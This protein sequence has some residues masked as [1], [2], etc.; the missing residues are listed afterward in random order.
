MR[1]LLR[2]PWCLVAVV[3]L[4]CS[5]V[6]RSEEVVSDA[7][8]RSIRTVIEAQIAAF[9][10]DDARRAF[11]YATPGIRR[12]I[13]TPERFIE[14]VRSSYPVVYRPLSVT[15]LQTAVVDGE[16]FQAVQMVDAEGALW[17][18]LYALER[19]PDKRWRISGCVVHKGEGRV[20]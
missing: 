1:N 18:A 2:R 13:G 15:F 12:E 19:Q 8:V 11:S 17:L 10:A 20:I 5:A 6:A 7:D 16:V 4:A 3:M 14:M 9:R